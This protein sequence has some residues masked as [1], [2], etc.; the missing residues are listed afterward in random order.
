MAGEKYIVAAVENSIQIG[1]R[2][3]L[4]PG[5]YLCLEH[6]RDPVSLMRL[7]RSYHPD[8]I[9]VD[10]GMQLGE[11]RSTLETVD[12]ELLCA[13][14][15]LGEYGDPIAYSIME[16]SKVISFCPKPLNRDLLLH[17]VN[18][19]LLNYKRILD[20][21]TQ[22]KKMTESYESRKQIDRAK[23]ILMQQG[24]SENDAYAMIR[25]RSMDERTTM[26]AIADSIIYLHKK[27]ESLK[28]S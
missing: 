10:S 26:R 3:I 13:C 1:V 20:L 24:L 16:R 28:G 19:T 25:K 4:N 6:C 12:D 7:I 15:L 8:F 18:M 27:E 21:N 23:A 5:G 11:A 17:T 14:I 22:L 2:N 9:V